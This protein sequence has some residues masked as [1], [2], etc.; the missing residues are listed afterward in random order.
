MAPSQNDPQQDEE[1]SSSV[2]QSLDWHIEPA[3]RRLSAPPR[4]RRPRTPGTSAG[5]WAM[6][7]AVLPPVTRATTTPTA[8]HHLAHTRGSTMFPPSHS[9]ELCPDCLE[10][11]ADPLPTQLEA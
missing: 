9:N 5:A 10:Q 8:R 6:R 7:A 11:F 2:N 4:P 1:P 3:L